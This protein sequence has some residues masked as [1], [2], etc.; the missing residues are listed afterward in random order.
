VTEHLWQRR[1][2]KCIIR[3]KFSNYELGWDKKL[4]RWRIT[5]PLT[6]PSWP[7]WPNRTVARI[8]SAALERL[9]SKG[10]DSKCSHPRQRPSGTCTIRDK[11]AQESLQFLFSLHRFKIYC[12]FLQWYAKDINTTYTHV[13]RTWTSWHWLPLTYYFLQKYHFYLSLFDLRSYFRDTT[14]EKNKAYA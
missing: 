3:D 11:S 2:G 8:L 1:Y 9:S 12:L 6:Q 13:F 7:V 14:R 4:R 10:C 5:Q